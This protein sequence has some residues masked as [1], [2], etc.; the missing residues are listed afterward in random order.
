MRS[1]LL[2]AAAALVCFVAGARAQPIP[3]RSPTPSTDPSVHPVVYAFH[4]GFHAAA[5]DSS[6]GVT[7]DELARFD[8]ITRT[9]TAH[10]RRLRLGLL[11]ADRAVRYFAPVALEAIGRAP[12]AARLRAL[13]PIT[14]AARARAASTECMAIREALSSDPSLT[15]PQPAGTILATLLT[16]AASADGSAAAALDSPTAERSA[17]EAGGGAAEVAGN[18]LWLLHLAQRSEAER[19]AVV[20]AA[21]RLLTRLTRAARAP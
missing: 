7:A 15:T 5:G 12:E 11:A 6:R 9:G 21:T 18:A 3:P 13:A 17:A 14:D 1:F 16:A 10:G 4:H 8:A 2:G 19:S 20:A